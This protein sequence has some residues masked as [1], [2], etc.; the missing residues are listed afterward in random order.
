MKRVRQADGSFVA[1]CNYCK[2]AYKW[3]KSGGCG[4]YQKH[5]T[6][7]HQESE[8]KSSSQTQIPRY[9]TPNQQLICYSDEQ[10]R[11]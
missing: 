3:H 6:S 5:I 9:A 10:N 2:K 7:K 1:V 11:E 4:T 8:A